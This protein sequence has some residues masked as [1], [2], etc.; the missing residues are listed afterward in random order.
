MDTDIP[1]DSLWPSGPGCVVYS[2]HRRVKRGILKAIIRVRRLVVYV[3]SRADHIFHNIFH[4]GHTCYFLSVCLEA[5]GYY[6][7]IAGGLFIMSVVAFYMH[8]DVD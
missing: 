3:Y 2:L 5:K 4:V 7:L 8:F 1:T 6:G